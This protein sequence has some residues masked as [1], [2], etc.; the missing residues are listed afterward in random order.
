MTSATLAV[1]EVVAFSDPGSAAA[2]ILAL[3]FQNIKYL[4]V[5]YSQ[6]LELTFKYHNSTYGPYKVGPRMPLDLISN[7]PLHAIPARFLKFHVHSSF[8]IN[9]WD[10]LIFLAILFGL[11]SLVA[12]IEWGVT[13]IKKKTVSSLRMGR[14]AIQCFSMM[15]FYNVLGD[16][17]LFAVLETQTKD[18]VNSETNLSFSLSILF[19][20]IGSLILGAH[21]YI[22]IRFSKFRKNPLWPSEIEEFSKKYEG[23]SV[24]FKHFKDSAFAS[25]SFLFFFVMRSCIFNLTLAFLPDQPEIQIS[26]ILTFSA[27]MLMYL[28]AQRPFKTIVN[29]LQHITCEILLLIVNISV[30]MITHLKFENQGAYENRDQLCDV[31]IYTTLVFGYVPQVFLV[32]KVIVAV[33]EWRMSKKKSSQKQVKTDRNVKIQKRAHN[34]TPKFITYQN[35]GLNDS[36]VEISMAHNISGLSHYHNNSLI[37]EYPDKGSS[38]LH[39]RERMSNSRKVRSSPRR[40]Q[41][42]DLSLSLKQTRDRDHYQ[43]HQQQSNIMKPGSRR[44]IV[45]AIEDVKQTQSPRFRSVVESNARKKI[46]FN[47]KNL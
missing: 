34:G 21:L 20:C 44:D 11:L 31:I 43:F 3:M 8:L 22:L 47:K 30:L 15:Q 46:L 27:I 32:I 38:P 41:L 24:I 37:I 25:Q 1:A 14:A 4:N 17:L 12:F 2:G 26:L 5:S 18:L 6:R 42:D 40:Q 36:S 13:K 39:Q 28:I 35:R 33:I 16:I 23:S 19:L 10:N 9:F 7:L 29:L 45:G